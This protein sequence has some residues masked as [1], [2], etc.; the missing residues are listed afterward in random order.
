LRT[1]IQIL[2]SIKQVYFAPR[3]IGIGFFAI[4]YGMMYFLAVMNPQ[5]WLKEIGV[6][7][8]Y[9][10]LFALASLP[11]A[12]KFIW[13]PAVDLIKIPFLTNRMGHRRSW[14]LVIHLLLIMSLLA[15][16]YSNPSQDHHLRTAVIALFIAFLAATQ[17][18]IVD[19]YRIEILDKKETVPGISMLIF[20]YRIGSITARAG[21]LYL[22]HFFSWPVAYTVMALLVI[23]GVLATIFNPE[24]KR[25]AANRSDLLYHTVVFPFQELLG[26]SKL[27][28]A[29]AAFILLYR[30][31]DAMINNMANIFYLEVGFTKAEIATVNNV[32]GVIA[33]IVGGF[34]GAAIVRKL[35]VFG[36]LFLCGI[37]HT[38][39]NLMFVVIALIG[40]SLPMLYTA[41]AVENITGGMSTAAFFVYLTRLCNL[42]FTAT[43]FALFTSLWSLQTP[44]ASISG[45]LIDSLN[46]N[47]V[48]FF[49]ITVLMALPGLFLV[50]VIRRYPLG[51]RGEIESTG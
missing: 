22:A 19:A 49:L 23:I 24:P 21:T 10:G 28:I 33:T 31:S 30:L 26:R 25:P 32:F 17:D 9:I 51:N 8:T 41:I 5:I 20:G 15:L 39:S 50:G 14:L 42:R 44:I 3:I 36:G 37:L 45:K 7:N 40:N 46:G 16:G 6:S 47:W 38:I 2:K 48:A 35:K 12:F 4:P 27:W 34:F 13:A 43:Q 29:V 11:Y 18:I 1:P